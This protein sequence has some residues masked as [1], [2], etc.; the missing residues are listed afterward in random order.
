MLTLNRFLEGFSLELD[1][2]L[3]ATSLA[4]SL[5][6][7]TLSDLYPAWK[8]SRMTTMDAIRH[9]V[10]SGGHRGCRGSPPA[11]SHRETGHATIAPGTPSLRR[12]FRDD[13]GG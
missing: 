6:I 10:T 3:M 2:W 4:G 11:P 12:S 5:A 1:P 13:R 9:S 7:A 8:A